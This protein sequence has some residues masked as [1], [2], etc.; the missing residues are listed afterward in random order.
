MR[1]FAVKCFLTTKAVARGG[2]R[3]VDVTVRAVLCGP[4]GPVAVEIFAAVAVV[5]GVGHCLPHLA[6]APQ[7]VRRAAPDGG[8]GGVGG[9][10]G[11]VGRCRVINRLQRLQFRGFVA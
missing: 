10:G 11:G 7:A 9:G 5:Q 2:A 3:T 6:H 4:C 8:V 1:P